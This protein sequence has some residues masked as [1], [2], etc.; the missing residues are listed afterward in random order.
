MGF[1]TCLLFDG[2]CPG[3]PDQGSVLLL[4][5][6]HANGF[7]N[8][9]KSYHS[10]KPRFL[11]GGFLG[12]SIRHGCTSKPSDGRSKPRAHFF[13]QTPLPRL[14]ATIQVASVVSRDCRP[15]REETM[16]DSHNKAA[17]HHES[18]AKSH[19]AAADS[20]GKNDHA[21]GKEHSTQAQQHSQNARDHSKTAH[22][23]SQQQK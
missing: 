6:G 10:P 5:L 14:L 22:E 18:A 8:H 12:T 7:E 2:R 13:V 9:S 15:T 20:H 17:E 4:F 21:K 19:R 1:E 23:K 11:I 16:K 3:V